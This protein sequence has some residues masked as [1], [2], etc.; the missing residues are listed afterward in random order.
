MRYPKHAGPA[1]PS[2]SCCFPLSSN[3]MRCLASFSPIW[4][5][6]SRL[7][8]AGLAA[9]CRGRSLRLLLTTGSSTLLLAIGGPRLLLTLL[10]CRDWP[11]CLF[12]RDASGCWLA[13][14]IGLAVLLDASG[15]AIGFSTATSCYS[16]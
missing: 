4:R 9:D 3:S 1:A 6:P 13:A 16:F 15:L 2:P 10:S 11:C 7:L 12:G 5:G 14:G 8:I